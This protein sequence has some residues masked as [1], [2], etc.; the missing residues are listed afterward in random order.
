MYYPHGPNVT[1][2]VL[3]KG[4]QG[5]RE[6]RIGRC[7]LL[8]LKMEPGSWSQGMQAAS[9]SWKRPQK[10]IFLWRLQK[11]QH[12]VNI[13]TSRTVELKTNKQTK[14]CNQAQWHLPIVLAPQEAKAGRLQVQ[15]QPGQFI[16]YLSSLG[17]LCLKLKKL[18]GLGK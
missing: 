4:K 18:K 11:K 10:P 7:A 9:G 12:P 6:R 13:L 3:I 16:K 2:R 1:R 14:P 15:D 5:W 8:A 17:R